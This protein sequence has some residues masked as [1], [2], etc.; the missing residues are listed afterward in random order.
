L[1]SVAGRQRMCQV[2]IWLDQ[3]YIE[4][5][6][7]H[8]L[9]AGIGNGGQRLFALPDLDLTVAVTAGHY[10]DPDQWRTPQT[11]LGRV[12]LPQ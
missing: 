5:M 7:G 3:W 11:V 4:S 8:R 6:G 1:T 9:V 10:D 2:R 12:I